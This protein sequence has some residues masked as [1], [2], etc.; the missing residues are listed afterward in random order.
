MSYYSTTTTSTS[1]SEA[2][3]SLSLALR[4]LRE[5]P[6][7]AVP[8][9]AFDSP[10]AQAFAEL[11]LSGSIIWDNVRVALRQYYGTVGRDDG[12]MGTNDPRGPSGN[13]VL[14]GDFGLELVVRVMKRFE[15]FQLADDE[16]NAVELAG[17]LKQAVWAEVYVASHARFAQG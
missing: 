17:L 2:F 11:A 15:R 6:A 4:S 9:V 16:K 10:A 7:S 8:Q 5:L 12:G 14:G 3:E 13:V 1:A